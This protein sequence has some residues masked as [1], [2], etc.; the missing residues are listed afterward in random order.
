MR[1]KVLRVLWLKKGKDVCIQ[2]TNG[3]WKWRWI[4][5]SSWKWLCPWHCPCRTITRESG[6]DML[7]VAQSPRSSGSNL[8]WHRLSP[9]K[10]WNVLQVPEVLEAFSDLAGNRPG[11]LQKPVQQELGRR[12]SLLWELWSLWRVLVNDVAFDPRTEN[13]GQHW[14]E[15][16]RVKLPVA[17]KKRHRPNQDNYILQLIN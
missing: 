2:Q 3:R 4:P 5:Q 7:E 16:L 1:T 8:Y 15:N 14:E 17:T 9:G 6:K 12:L 13:L 11:A 10:P